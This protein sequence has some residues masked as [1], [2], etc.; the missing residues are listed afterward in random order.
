M[1]E[2]PDK[3][4][5]TEEGTEKHVRDSVEKGKVPI[6]REVHVLASLLG[7]LAVS[8]FFVQGQVQRLLGQLA[9]MLDD[10]A[11]YPLRNGADAVQLSSAVALEMGRF[12]LP[13]CSVFLLF[14]VGASILQNAPRIAFDR[15]KP[16]LSRI[17]FGKGFER[18]FGVQGQ[19][20]FGK[21]L[22]KFAAISV[23]VFIILRAEQVTT[24]NAMFS[25][26]TAIPE[27]L[28]RLAVQLVSAI[29]IAT[30]VLV[31]GDLVWARIQWRRDLRMSRQEVKD[32]FKQSE[33]DPAVKARLRSIA[34]DRSRRRMLAAVPRASFVIVNPTHYAVALRYVRGNDAAPFVL[35]KGADLIALKIRET[36]EAHEIPVIENK[37]LARSLYDGVEIDQ[38]IPAE[39]YQT[40]AEIIHYLHDAKLKA[41]I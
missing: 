31:A 17:S 3:E 21:A 26:P 10:P 39:F 40:V 11:G 30:I 27:M 35:A 18:I 5:K 19:V 14:G 37:A 32:E 4:N 28:L 7:F 41:P 36:A 12:L 15:I 38:F 9:Q 13:V 8:G 34:R 33:G 22:F 24:M 1:S 6:S 16:D 23:V 2:A 20:E 25:D 29:S